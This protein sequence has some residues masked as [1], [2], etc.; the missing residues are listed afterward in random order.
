MPAAE[1]R[2]VS[3][4]FADL[5]GFTT[6]SES[7][8]P[9][10]V[11]ELLTSY[12]DT[13]RRLIARYGGTVEKFIGDAVMAVWGAPVAKEDDA[14]RAVRAALELTAAVA[15]LGEEAG[16]ADLRARAGVL[17]GEAAVTLGAEGQGMV[18]G[19]L[20]NTAS[21]IQAAAKPGACSSAT[22]PSGRATL[23]SPTR[24]PEL[25]ELKGKAEPMQ[26][27]RAVRVVG[28]RRGVATSSALEPPFVGR[29]R[30]LR[31]VKEHYHA[32]ADEH[33]TNLVSVIGVGGIGKSRLAWEFEKYF[34]GLAAD[35]WWH[36]GRCLAYGDG[37][38]F[39]ALAEM[40]RGRAGIVEDEDSVS[41]SAK[42]RAIVDDI[43]P[44]P[45]ERRFVEPRLAQ[46]LGLEDRP[47]GD[48][49]NLFAAWRLFFERMSDA[50]PVILIF[51]DIHWADSALLDFIEHL[52]DWSRER[53]IFIL[54][55]SRPELLDRRPTW[56]AGKRGFTSI[57]LEPLPPEAMETLLAGPLPGLP[58]DILEKILQRA[59]GVPF[60][61]VETVRMLLD[62]G[63][64]IREG[65]VFRSTGPIETL[66][67]PETLQALIAARLDGLATEERR[68][69]QRASVLGKS[70]TLQG[71]AAV[72]G[73]EESQLESTLS[74]LVHKEVLGVTTD[75]MSPNEASTG[76]C[77]I[78]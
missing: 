43:V 72:T 9:E 45:N 1:R 4:L 67:V 10:E 62:R 64:I 54:T 57:F 26:L 30:E 39:W 49:A 8:D 11:R 17:T 15:T 48:E 71:L 18:A 73:I 3:V 28:L 24:T 44:D 16:A 47:P 22:R 52:L 77:R 31:L 32:T 13:C 20:V 66:E 34:D 25:H 38:A 19:D 35:A 36:R 14:E 37:V 41:A 27:W 40:V 70:F 23:R 58:G 76:S 59:E 75:P 60:Y 7:R 29:D 63:L 33:R 50:D 65:N 61:A 55:L 78:W 6:I 5:V 74:S 68:L 53:P 56:G 51:E 12:F 21:R 69:L 2:L 42:L 46:L